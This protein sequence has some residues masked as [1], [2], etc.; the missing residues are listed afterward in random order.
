VR[1][2]VITVVTPSLNAR[3]TVE[4]TLRSVRMQDYPHVEHVVID[5]GSTDGTVE[6][7]ERAEGIRFVSERDGGLSDA[8]NKGIASATGDVIGWLN[9]DDCY[10]PGA[11]SRV[12]EA[13]RANP[14]ALW[15][16]GRCVIIDGGG[17]EIRRPV[18]M[19]KNFL[20][21]NYRHWLYLT[22]NFISAPATFV[23]KRG[24]ELAGP[25][26]ER[27]RI[28]MDYDL[29]LR[30]AKLAD[31]VVID[32][33][34]SCFRMAHA[35]GSLSMSAFERQFREHALNAREHGAG[36][37]LPV[38]INQVLSRLIVAAYKSMRWLRD[39]RV[40]QLGNRRA[41]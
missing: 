28:S 37:P 1:D 20:L 3:A 24:Y 40:G 4:Q 25:Y 7:L 9:A 14:D 19:Y 35:S 36:H 34:L 39:R 26:D 27:F 8:M 11:L 38:A 5:G 30:L 15:A 16:T 41:G 21:R 33:D 12:A 31:P 6:I 32:A 13:F 29:Y 17:R 10:L 23:H 2:P 22:Q 18:R